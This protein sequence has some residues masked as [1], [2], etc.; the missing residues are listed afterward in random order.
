M[1]RSPLSRYLQGRVL[2]SYSPALF[3][4]LE[5]DKRGVVFDRDWQTVELDSDFLAVAPKMGRRVWEHAVSAFINRVEVQRGVQIPSQH[6]Q[7][8]IDPLTCAH[9]IYRL[10]DNSTGRMQQSD[11]AIKDLYIFAY[12]M[13]TIEPVRLDN[14]VS[15]LYEPLVFLMLPSGET[16]YTPYASTSSETTPSISPASV[17]DNEEAHD[18]NTA[19]A[20]VQEAP[21][22][23]PSSH[24]RALDASP[25]ISHGAAAEEAVAE[26]RAKRQRSGVVHDTTGSHVAAHD[27][28]VGGVL[29]TDNIGS[30]SGTRVVPML[31]NMDLDNEVA[32]VAQMNVIR[33]TQPEVGRTANV[34]FSMLRSKLAAAPA[35]IARI[36]KLHVLPW[37]KDPK[38]IAA[39]A[40]CVGYALYSNPMWLENFK[41]VFP[42]G[43]RTLFQSSASGMNSTASAFVPTNASA[44]HA[45]VS[46][47]DTTTAVSSLASTASASSV[48]TGATCA[49]LSAP[50]ALPP[51][52]VESVRECV[53]SQ[54]GENA[55]TDAQVE[56]F[57]KFLDTAVEEAT[58]NIDINP[59]LPRHLIGS[60]RCEG[61]ARS[62]AS[63]YFT[64]QGKLPNWMFYTGIMKA[65]LCGAFTTVGVVEPIP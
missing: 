65:A 22:D 13:H 60:I 64:L 16:P 20:G 56:L 34:I 15:T 24:K 48:A 30:A 4:G 40:L 8:L 2:C 7:D 33:E 19:V 41:S 14:V 39:V 18:S 9:I 5:V 37:A 17:Q 29:D 35:E 27:I 28:R 45:A 23:R 57:I 47:L 46:S 51:D 59:E 62:A 49:A 32:V 11:K 52:L 44:A 31:Q 36:S 61:S 38:F 25:D 10:V 54:I 63:Y 58:P 26:P 21:T 50:S 3:A 6:R 1:M 53:V 55:A 42:Q 43:L 12:N